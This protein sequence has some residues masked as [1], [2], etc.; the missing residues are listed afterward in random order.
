MSFLSGKA[1]RVFIRRLIAPKIAQ[2]ATQF[3]VVALM[4]PR[5]SGKTT[6]LR[7]TFPEYRYVSLEDPDMRLFAMEDPRAFLARFSDRVILDEIQTVPELLGYLPSTIK[8]RELEASA[9]EA[10]KEETPVQGAQFII[11]S[12]LN[13]LLTEDIPQAL[14]GQVA[15]LDLLPLALAELEASDK[16]PTLLQ[17]WLIK[18]GH[19]ALYTSRARPS[20]YFSSYLKTNL[21]RGLRSKNAIT[22]MDEFDRFIAVCASRIGKI[23]NM[24]ALS[25]EASINVRTA[26]RWFGI[27]EAN[28]IVIRL[29]PYYRD[30]GNRLFKT[31]KTYF[32]D[33]G[34]ACALLGITNE[35]VLDVG[36]ERMALFENAVM[37]EFVKL[38][39]A[40]GMSPRMYFWR[41]NRH[42]QIDLIAEV[43]G[44]EAYAINIW[45]STTY[46]PSAFRH[47]NTVCDEIGIPKEYRIVVWAGEESFATSHGLVVSYR[48]IATYIQI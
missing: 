27:L 4:G 20:D 42:R 19:P 44:R 22:K 31:T 7:K 45:S 36:T 15:I 30:E 1:S 33:T 25:R 9:A 43:E 37:L 6:L 38:Y 13:L 32:C 48:D 46:A 14:A 11:C 2:L 29:R 5:H 41:D 35:N 8:R 39:C 3:P 12:S 40:K 21:E 28:F 23:H 18:G 16:A 26:R 17:Q 34:L 24:D 47:L 10:I